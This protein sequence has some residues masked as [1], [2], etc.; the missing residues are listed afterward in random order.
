[1]RKRGGRRNRASNE[2]S[3][4][5]T[6]TSDCSLSNWTLFVIHKLPSGAILSPLKYGATEGTSAY[7]A[8]TKAWTA[9]VRDAASSRSRRAATARLSIGRDGNGTVTRRTGVAVESYPMIV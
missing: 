9:G 1:M 5:K 8:L 4:D 6:A 3:W 2:P 7:F